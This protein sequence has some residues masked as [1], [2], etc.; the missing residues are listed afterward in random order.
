MK[1]VA[2]S[3]ELSNAPTHETIGQIEMII[4]KFCFLFAEKCKIHKKTQPSFKAKN[5]VKK[6]GKMFCFV[7]IAVNKITLWKVVK[8]LAS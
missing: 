5:T 2:S 8:L 1:K 4:D 3:S 7:F 6:V